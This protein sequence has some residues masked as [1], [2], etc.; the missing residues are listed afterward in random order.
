MVDLSTSFCKRSESVY[1][2]VYRKD[3]HETVRCI[4]TLVHPYPAAGVELEKL[5]TMGKCTG[6]VNVMQ[7]AIQHIAIEIC[8]LVH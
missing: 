1:Q 6:A 7:L 3:S 2:R 5:F 8:L 4:M